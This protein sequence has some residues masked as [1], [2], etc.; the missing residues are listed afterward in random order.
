MVK[1]GEEKTQEEVEIS[2]L[3]MPRGKE[4]LGV[5]E[6]M[7]GGDKLRVRC[8]DGNTRLSR[9][10]G[11]LRKRVWIRINDLVLVE[12]WDAQT[13]ERADIVFRYTPTQANWLR[14][15]SQTKGL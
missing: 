15:R 7:L 11:K 12:P 4:V 13:N 9:I 1:Y 2:R 10:P 5:V 8:E 14:R 3:R 6:A